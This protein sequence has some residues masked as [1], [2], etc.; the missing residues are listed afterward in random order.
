MTLHHIGFLVK[1]FGKALASFQR[2]GYEAASD[3]CYDQI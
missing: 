1:D 3:E 2:L